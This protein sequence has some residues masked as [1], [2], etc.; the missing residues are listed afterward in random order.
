MP[1][2]PIGTLMRKIQCQLRYVVRNPP[3]GGPTIGPISPGM[4]SQAIAST[5]WLRGVMRTSTSRAIGVIIAP[6]MPCRNR[7]PTKVKSEFE[8]AQATEPA[9]NT[10]IATRK[11][12]RD[13]HRSAIQLEIGM[14]M[15]S[16]TR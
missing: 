11:T 10:R 12:L 2:S 4:L 5:S 7:E 3:T 13:P 1:I 8:I 15:A 9:M 14:K 16:A 6:P